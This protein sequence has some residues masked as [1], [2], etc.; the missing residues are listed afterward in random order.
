MR[1]VLVLYV[2]RPY[3]AVGHNRR[4]LRRLKVSRVAQ[5]DRRLESIC[6]PDGLRYCQK[7]E[8]HLHDSLV[9][10]KAFLRTG[11]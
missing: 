8:K 7:S 6:L 2:L 3:L 10:L 9:I 11:E 4:L 5:I 1:L